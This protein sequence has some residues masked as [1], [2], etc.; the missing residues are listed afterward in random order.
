MNNLGTLT[1]LAAF[2]FALFSL[3]QT[4]FGIW[5]KNQKALELG[6]YSLLG[7]SGMVLL[8]FV[9]LGVQLFRTDLT[10]Y[11]VVMHSSEHL[12]LFYKLTAIWAGSSGSLLFWNL[13]LNV[14][15]IAVTFQ[16]RNLPNNRIPVMNISLAVMTGFF[17]FLAVFYPDAQPFREFQPAAITG[18]GLNP[19]LQH[20]A[21]IIHPPILYIGYV[22]FAIPFSIATSALI[23]G[24]LS[25]DWLKFI[26]KWSL[27]SWFFLGVGILLG[28]AWA[29]EELGW[30]GYWAW[31]PV[32]N[33]SLMPFL[34]ASAFIHSL[35]I[36]ERRGMLKFWNMLLII[37]AFHFCLLGTWITRSGVLEGPHSFA[38]ST[39]GTP[40]IIYIGISFFTYIIF[41]I[42]RYNELKPEKTLEAITSKEGSFFLNNLVL[43][44]STLA[45]LLGVFSPLLYNTEFKAPWYNSWGIPAGILLLFLMGAAPLL[46]WRKGADSIFFSTLLKPL[47]VGVIGSGLYILFYSRLFIKE[48]YS[49]SGTVN[50]IYSAIT[51]G[52]GIFA[53]A[54][55]VQEYY[56]GIKARR[57]AFTDENYI[58][59]AYKMLLKNKRRYGGYLVH[60]AIILLF[61]GYSGNAF[62]QSTSVKFYYYLTKPVGNEVIYVSQDKSIINEY[63][64]EAT[65]LKLKPLINGDVGAPNIQ[66]VIVAQE[67]TYKVKKNLAPF[68]QMVTE[69]RFYPQISHLTGD[70]ETHIPTSEPSISSSIFED[71][72]IQLGAT[73]YADSTKGENPDMPILFMNYFF[74]PPDRPEVKLRQYMNFPTELIANLEIWVNPMINFIWLGSV[75]FFLVGLFIIWPDTHKEN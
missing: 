29:Y 17:S 19:L 36:Q 11:Y 15:I 68:A 48:T 6:R 63:E 30:G 4:T 37:L 50:E 27:F 64:I 72:Y 43:V 62:K 28:S 38:K 33:A 44:I 25:V 18:R 16:T 35:I 45:I 46:S 67:A 69:R 58:Q 51:V 65:T 71:L 31:D 74:S 52:V 61:I 20:W 53:I 5:Q 22:S 32:E 26:R 66:N 1:L 70:F 60:F 49:T 75:L 12:P 21:M 13:L 23:T 55:I 41:L 40:F 34:L 47:L 2:G 59:S 57:K 7:N 8:A 3:I 24:N 39:I 56:R 14:F 10:N 73:E 54:G 9:I 42:Y